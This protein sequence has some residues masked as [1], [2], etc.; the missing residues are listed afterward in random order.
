MFLRFG[1]LIASSLFSKLGEFDNH[2]PAALRG[3]NCWEVY[4]LKSLDYSRIYLLQG[5]DYTGIYGHGQ[6]PYSY[7]TNYPY[8]AG[9][10]GPTTPTPS[11][12]STQTYQLQDLP[13]ANTTTA[14]NQ[15]RLD[16]YDR[17]I[18]IY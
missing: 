15:G 9:S 7:P 12:P 1:N 8:I 17:N 18:A 10:T 6:T 2:V 14:N 11:I 13:P 3:L 16:V 4:L 5:L